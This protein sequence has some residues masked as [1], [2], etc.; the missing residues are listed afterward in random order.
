M[1][2]QVFGKLTV[3]S[4][5]SKRITPNGTVRQRWLCKCECGGEKCVNQNDLRSKNTTA[6][7]ECVL[8]RLKAE[9]SKYLNGYRTQDCILFIGAKNNMGYGNVSSGGRVKQSHVV[10]LELIGR[11]TPSGMMVRHKCTAK[12]CVNPE[13]L[14]F[15]TRRDNAID[16]FRDSTVSSNLT[17]LQIIDIIRRR[18][19]GETQQAIAN[20]FH[21]SR[22][23][24]SMITN[25]KKWIH[26]HDAI[27]AIGIDELE[28]RL[29]AGKK[30]YDVCRQLKLVQ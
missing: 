15:G 24:I 23:E 25:G 17:E 3:V 18:L 12:A 29:I 2:G 21:V 20:H 27:S 28:S 19:L 13:H 6:C 4:E 30:C 26:V 11:P 5:A 16:R 10:M 8:N 22:P 9:A 14:E 1:I 7:G